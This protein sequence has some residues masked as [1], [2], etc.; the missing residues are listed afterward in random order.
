MVDEMRFRKADAKR[1]KMYPV[2]KATVIDIGDLLYHDTNDVK[3]ASSQADQLSEAKNQDV[4]AAEFAGIA[5]EAST[6]ADSD[7]IAVAT[8]GV[9][10]MDSP[11]ATYEIGDVL[12]PDEESGGTKLLDQTVAAISGTKG[13][14]KI[15][16]RE[17]ASVTRVL[18]EI[19]ASQRPAA[20]HDMASHK[21]RLRSI[22]IEITDFRRSAGL[23][24]TVT[25]TE[26]PHLTT[27]L[28]VIRVTW[29]AADVGAG[30]VRKQ[31]PKDYDNNN[32]S[33]AL[34][35]YVLETGGTDTITI[36]VNV[37]VIR[38]GQVVGAD[39]V[40]GTL[41]VTQSGTADTPE[42][43]TITI[44]ASTIQKG[45]ILQIELVP[46]AHGTDSLFLYGGRLDYNAEE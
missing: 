7:D 26:E 5:M 4:F 21:T 32:L 15:A 39:I 17:S 40:T 23:I 25:T 31:M 9:F 3:P 36:A 24:L 43:V 1:I 30:V 6:D 34:F 8:L 16:R 45:D 20:M 37:F 46:G 13:I 27:S 11:S 19:D 12:G 22:P 29:A 42:E 28:N 38:A 33:L 35:V 10:E 41:A 14:G 44:P 18:M 2:D